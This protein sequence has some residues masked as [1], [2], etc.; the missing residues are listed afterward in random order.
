[1][2]QGRGEGGGLYNVFPKKSAFWPQPFFYKDTK[3]TIKL[4]VTKF[5]VMQYS[6]QEK[7]V[8]EIEGENYKKKWDG[9]KVR[10]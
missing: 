7:R 5:W 8:F 1:M 3:R 4:V 10:Q 2:F 9:V 6:P